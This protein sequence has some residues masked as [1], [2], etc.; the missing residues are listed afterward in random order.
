MADLLGSLLPEGYAAPDV[1][2]ALGGDLW[3]A[4][5]SEWGGIPSETCGTGSAPRAVCDVGSA[6]HHHHRGYC[7][8]PGI[9][10]YEGE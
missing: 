4:S 7:G 10:P 9:T 6:P 8:N 2:S 5:C 1:Q 3:L